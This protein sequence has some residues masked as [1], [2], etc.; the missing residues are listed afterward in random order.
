MGWNPEPVLV[1]NVCVNKQESQMQPII[2]LE[3]FFHNS[4][5]NT[6]TGPRVLSHSTV[7]MRYR[8]ASDTFS[9]I[10]N[11]YGDTQLVETSAPV[12]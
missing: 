4:N 11:R 5:T 6:T 7:P 12:W 3:D 1:S 10:S 8:I 2:L 9:K